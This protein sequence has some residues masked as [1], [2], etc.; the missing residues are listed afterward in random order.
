[1]IT[2][3]K[4]SYQ[5]FQSSDKYICVLFIMIIARFIIIVNR[6][7]ILEKRV[8]EEVSRGIKICL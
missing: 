7:Y 8:R 2:N 6:Y 5:T 4:P 1:M 3:L